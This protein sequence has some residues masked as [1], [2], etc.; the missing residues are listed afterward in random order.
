[1]VAFGFTLDRL[2]S[3]PREYFEFLT[4][5]EVLLSVVLL[6]GIYFCGMFFMLL[7]LR[8]AKSNYM[9]AKQSKLALE[10]L[11]ESQQSNPPLV[12]YLRFSIMNAINNEDHKF[13]RRVELEFQEEF[14]AFNEQ[15][16]LFGS[17][18]EEDKNKYVRLLVDRINKEMESGS[19]LIPQSVYD[20]LN[21]LRGSNG[22]A[23]Q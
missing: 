5:S 12:N 7:S 11:L 10:A 13:I 8:Q 19:P 18:S 21:S 15:T 20:E 6:V 23:V 2:G 16:E 1:M 14:K 3:T 17:L 22:G 4:S 9:L